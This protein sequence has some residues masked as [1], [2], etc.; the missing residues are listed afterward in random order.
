MGSRAK[1]LKARVPKGFGST[2]TLNCLS[3]S[4]PLRGDPL[5]PAV[6]CE[7]DVIALGRSGTRA[8]EE[9][10]DASISP[11]SIVLEIALDTG[12]R[13]REGDDVELFGGS[14]RSARVRAGS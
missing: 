1:G 6:C 14:I 11:S 9:G 10:C 12:V 8:G 4:S 2:E 3:H 5:S 13:E 7:V